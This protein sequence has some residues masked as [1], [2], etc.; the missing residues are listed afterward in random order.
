[1][2]LLLQYLRS[3]IESTLK[4]LLQH[5]YLPVVRSPT[6]G[7]S[8]ADAPQVMLAMVME[9]KAAQAAAG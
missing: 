1:V 9:R 8:R 7:T 6:C 4:F 2:K 5:F 3:P